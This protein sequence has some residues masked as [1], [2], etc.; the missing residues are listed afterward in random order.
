M[1]LGLL[2]V[3]TSLKVEFLFKSFLVITVIMI[4]SLKLMA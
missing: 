3:V 1:I 2:K 4:I